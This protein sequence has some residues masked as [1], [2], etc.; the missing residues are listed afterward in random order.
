MAN[1][2][3]NPRNRPASLADVE[4]AK[5]QASGEAISLAIALFLTVMVDKFGYDAES[6]K[7]V[8]DAVNKLSQEVSE[9]RV[10]LH[11]LKEV[12]VDEYGIAIS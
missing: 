8:W 9:G 7:A 12:L 5:K 3:V 6:L 10:N 11:D 4:K 2:K 1:K